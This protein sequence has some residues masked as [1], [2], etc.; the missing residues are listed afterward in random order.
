MTGH[1]CQ[2][3]WM[4]PDKYADIILKCV[5]GI[6]DRNGDYWSTKELDKSPNLWKI[7]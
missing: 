5:W 6:N 2:Q 3:L 1:A 4:E 7:Y